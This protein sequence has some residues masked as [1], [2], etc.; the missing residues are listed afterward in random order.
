VAAPAQKELTAVLG[1]SLGAAWENLA[2]WR[3]LGISAT[4]ALVVIMALFVPRPLRSP[5]ATSYLAVLSEPRSQKPVLVISAARNDM[6]RWVTT[7][8]PAIHAAD[9]SSLELWALPKGR[10]PR[11]L[12]VV[13]GGEK[14]ALPLGA[15]AENALRD[16]TILAVSAEPKGGSRSGAPT[17]P[18]LYSGL[19]VK[20]W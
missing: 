9:G 13:A 2:F 7:L 16:V 18:V 15:V 20:Y 4:L 17:G 11:S 8:E 3:A 12:G 14:I 19:C 6:Q 1:R 10:A 5:L